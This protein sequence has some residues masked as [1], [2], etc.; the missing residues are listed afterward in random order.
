MFFY[1]YEF[2]AKSISPVLR[3]EITRSKLKHSVSL[4][5]PRSF[6]IEYISNIATP[7]TLPPSCASS[8]I[9]DWHY[10]VHQILPVVCL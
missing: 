1:I 3:N 9:E 5:G 7:N 4:P 2:D 6:F 10:L 8:T